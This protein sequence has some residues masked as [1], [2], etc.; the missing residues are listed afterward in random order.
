MTPRSTDP[1]PT[2]VHVGI[3]ADTTGF[4]HRVTEA[5]GVSGQVTAWRA[6]EFD[7][8]VSAD[9]GRG[10]V[11]IVAS[12]EVV[13]LEWGPRRAPLL[14]RLQDEIG[15]SDVPV[16]AVC[17]RDHDRAS[18]LMAGADFAV[19]E[20]VSAET[21]RS[22]AV[23]HRRRLNGWHAFQAAQRG[24]DVPVRAGRDPGAAGVTDADGLHSIEL[25]PRTL[26]VRIGGGWH[27]LPPRRFA[28]LHHL[29]SHAGEVV[30]RDELLASVWNVPFDPGSNTVEVYVHHL[31]RFLKAHDFN[32]RLETVRNVGYRLVLLPAAGG[33]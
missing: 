30:T 31:R 6:S 17:S 27:Q 15:W 8:E 11:E 33:G 21:V 7:P 22:F 20:P 26:G 24:A 4:V 10:L 18:A 2:L 16:V 29:F 9:E 13:L 32:G 25:S 5:L 1:P 12:S 28:L 19:V 14:V 3:L 23:A